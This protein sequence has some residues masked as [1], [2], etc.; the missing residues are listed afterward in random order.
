M[1]DY[2]RKSPSRAES[3]KRVL[4]YLAAFRKDMS[5]EQFEHFREIAMK[6]GQ[7]FGHLES[8][9]AI[10]NEI[11]IATHPDIPIRS[12]PGYTMEQLSKL[13]AD[14]GQRLSVFL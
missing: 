6:H 9:A 3:S 8:I 5:R 4:D 12:K 14:F 1:T 13:L 11:H 7:S 10:V 2:S